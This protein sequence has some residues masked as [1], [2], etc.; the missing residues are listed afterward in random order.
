MSVGPVEPISR[1]QFFLVTAIS[2][3]AGGVY[4]WPQT[5]LTDAGL[6]A[7]WAVLLSISVAL[8]ITWLQTLW[9][10]KTTGM[11]EFRRMQAVWGWARWPVFLATAALY[12]PLD[13]AFLALF[14]QLLHQLYYRY[15]PL[16]FFAVTVLLM[17]GWL[18]GH[19]L[20]YVARNVQ[21]WFPLI[22]ASFLFLVFM[23]LGH[24]REIAALHP[25]SVIRVVPIA[26]GMVATWYL[27]MQG[28]VIVTVGSHVRDTS[29]TQIRHWALAA[30]AFQGAIIVVIYALVVGTLGPALADTL[31][32]P[33]V[34]IF[35]NLTV[36]T[37]FISRPSILI[38]VSWVVALLLYLTL[39][40]FVLT[41]NLQDGLSLSPRGRV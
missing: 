29:W 7:P 27:W 35:S 39:H 24:F 1:G 41:I 23:A 25:A 37:L 21:L 38:V 13:A 34:Y 33:L 22:I 15:T 11:T 32:W 2:V 30:V 14:S 9:P 40:V 5:V 16:W 12:V 17:V 8:A 20:T 19:S 6:D 4:I 18:A 36:R 3:V 26:K 31:E 28:E 10:A